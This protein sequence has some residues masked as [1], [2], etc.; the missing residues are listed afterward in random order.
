MNS[1][2]DNNKHNH[3]NLMEKIKPK[4]RTVSGQNDE[5]LAEADGSEQT[6]KSSSPRHSSCKN[7]DK[8]PE[9]IITKDGQDD[10]KLSIP[11]EHPVTIF[12][13]EV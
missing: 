8:S 2:G 10:K 1:N 9:E 5:K 11:R 12:T 7:Q 3:S 6:L 13:A 4:K